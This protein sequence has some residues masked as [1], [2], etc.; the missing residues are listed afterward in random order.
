MRKKISKRFLLCFLFLFL[1]LTFYT[2]WDNNRVIIVKE[3]VKIENLPKGLEGFKIVQ[4]TDLHE[5][6]FGNNQKQLILAIN[7]IDYDAIVFTGDMLDGDKSKNYKPFYSLLEGLRNK[8]NALF[9]PGNS[10]PKVFDESSTIPFEKSDFIKGMEKR[11]VTLLESIYTITK[12]DSAIHFVDFE[13]SILKSPGKTEGIVER[14]KPSNVTYDQFDNYQKRLIEEIAFL[15]K[16]SNEDL[17]VAL[18]HYPVVDIRID[19][20]KNDNMYYFKEYDLILAGHYHGGQIRIPF[21]GAMFVP[22]GWYGFGGLLPPR[23]RVKGI[24][25]YKETKQYVSA[26]LGSSDAISWLK[27]RLFNPPEINVLTF[28]RGE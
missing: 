12:G 22:E 11:G 28:T 5:K 1:L 13:T 26:G 27:F 25:E 21:F 19:T 24:W 17:I 3:E 14:S 10:D 18:N 9:V 20:L 7:S 15:D 4:V 23:N 2:V 8:R 6:E 16:P